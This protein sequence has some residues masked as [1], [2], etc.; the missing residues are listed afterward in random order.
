MENQVETNA[1][2]QKVLQ[3]QARMSEQIKSMFKRIDEQKA[4][5]ESVHELAVSLKLLASAQKSTEQKVDG[6]ASDVEAIKQKPAKRWDSVSA[7]AI[8]AIVTAVVAYALA[9]VGL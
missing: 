3:D 9:R 4:L 2:I 8:T 5:T 7:V 1:T 6:L